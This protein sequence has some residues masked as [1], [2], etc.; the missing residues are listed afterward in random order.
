MYLTD[1][2]IDNETSYPIKSEREQIELLGVF[3]DLP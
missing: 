1:M 2:I 3:K